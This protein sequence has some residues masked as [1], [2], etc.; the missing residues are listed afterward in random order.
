MGIL[1]EQTGTRFTVGIAN[2]LPDAVGE[3]LAKIFG[4]VL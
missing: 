2:G 4:W 3:V 1:H